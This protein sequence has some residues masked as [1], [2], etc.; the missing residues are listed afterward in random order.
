M[1]MIIT[2]GW[3]GLGLFVSLGMAQWLLF[4]RIR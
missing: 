1:G 3:L 2:L 4:R